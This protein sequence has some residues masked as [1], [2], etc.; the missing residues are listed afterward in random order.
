MKVETEALKAVMREVQAAQ[1]HSADRR[2]W[3]ASL[4]TV[5][6]VEAELARSTCTGNEGAAERIAWCLGQMVQDP[7]ETDGDRDA[8]QVNL[9]A[10][11]LINVYGVRD[12]LFAAF[13]RMQSRD[14]PF[15]TPEFWENWWAW[16]T[17]TFFNTSA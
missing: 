14:Q 11:K 3:M 16:M 12:A 13:L 6:S 9:L 15:I 8:E 4:E 1:W 5:L 7:L 17:R 10:A 2:D